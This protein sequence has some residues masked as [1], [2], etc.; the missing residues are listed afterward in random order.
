MAVRFDPKAAGGF[1]GRIA[2]ELARPVTEAPPIRWTLEVS[3]HR[4]RARPGADDDAAVRLRITL[5][6]FIRI[7]A[8]TIDPATPVLQGRASFQ[9]DFGLVVRLPEMFR[10]SPRRARG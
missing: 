5:A 10:A 9:G 1:E 7:G 4:A 6:D 8:G 2:Y 3:G